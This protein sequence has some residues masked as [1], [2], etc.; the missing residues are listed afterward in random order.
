MKSLRDQHGVSERRAC[1]VA[2][3]ARATQRRRGQSKAEDVR[4]VAEMRRHA[5]AHPRWGTRRIL[6]LLKR[7]G[8]RLNHKRLERLWRREGLQ[9]PSKRRK[10]RRLG[11]SR[12]GCQRLRAEH[13]NHVWSYDFV[14]DR[15]ADGRRLKILTLIDEY[16]REALTVHVARSITAKEVVGILIG[17]MAQRGCPKFIRSDNGPEFVARVVRNWL[18][19]CGVQAAFIAPGS[20]WENGFIESFNGKL[21]DE[22]LS[23]EVF[24]SLEEARW[25]GRRFFE[26][27]NHHRPHL[28]L[29]GVTPAAF[30]A[31][32]ED[33]VAGTAISPEKNPARSTVELS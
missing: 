20:P 5:A 23:Q 16:T 26:D 33:G 10:R 3:Q 4:L 9:V 24:G 25:L 22:L 6:T 29:G 7:D 32:L 17:V 8:W 27:Y 30:A 31:S 13:R 14:M 21:E 11:H 15:T 12:N 28:G 1:R 18:E 19:T 2:G